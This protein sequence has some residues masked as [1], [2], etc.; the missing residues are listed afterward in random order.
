MI[1]LMKLRYPNIHNGA[2]TCD[3]QTHMTTTDALYTRGNKES[4]TYHI[5]QV[6]LDYFYILQFIFSDLVWTYVM[7]CPGHNSI[8][9]QYDDM[10]D[11]AIKNEDADIQ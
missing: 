10:N 1:T 2:A 6:N 9:R 3:N 11:D 7:Q 8:G 5:K 4:N